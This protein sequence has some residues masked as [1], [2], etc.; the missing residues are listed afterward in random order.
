MALQ[1]I[2]SQRWRN[3]RVLITYP[4]NTHAF[5][6]HDTAS[7]QM[8]AG[9]DRE[10]EGEAERNVQEAIV[11]TAIVAV[12]VLHRTLDD[13]LRIIDD[14]ALTTK[15][16]RMASFD[17]WR[18]VTVTTRKQLCPCRSGR[19]AEHCQHWWGAACPAVLA[20]FDNLFR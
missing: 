15:A 8:T 16:P 18:K 17:Y 13:S 14:I 12:T 20:G 7:L 2:S 10:T 4:A 9:S 1:H 5:V 11:K 3:V 6:W 19:R